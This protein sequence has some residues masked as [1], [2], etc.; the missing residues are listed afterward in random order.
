MK[1]ELLL[2]ITYYQLPITSLKDITSNLS[3]Y[4]MQLHLNLVLL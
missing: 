2:P 3:Y 4:C 1:L